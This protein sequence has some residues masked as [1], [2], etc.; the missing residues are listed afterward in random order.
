MNVAVATWW[1]SSTLEVVHRC[2]QVPVAACLT[3][4]KK[5][6]KSW[7]PSLGPGDEMILVEMGSRPRPLDAFSSDQGKLDAALESLRPLDVEPDLRAAL[8][9]ARDI[10]SAR[11]SPEIIVVGD[12]R[13]GHGASAEEIENLPPLRF[14]N[15]T[16]RCNPNRKTVS[17][18]LRVDLFSARRY[19]LSGDRFEVLLSVS[20][21]GSEPVEV[22]LSISAMG[23]EGQ[24]G[25]LLEVVRREILPGAPNAFSFANLSQ[26]EDGL[27]AEIRRLDG[28]SDSLLSD[29]WALAV[30]PRRL[31]VRVLIVGEPDNFLEAALLIEDSLI[32]KSVL[33]QDYER[34]GEF[35]VTV[36]NGVAPKRV[37]R[38]GAAV[39]LGPSEE[40]ETQGNAE[41]FPVERGPAISMFGFDTWDKDSRVFQLV[42]PYDVQVLSGYALVPKSEDRVLAKSEDRPILIEGRRD[43]GS[44]LALG[45][46]PIKSDFVLR[47]AW[48]LF[49]IN[50]IDELYPRGRGDVIS[51]GVASR[52]LRVP[53]AR[54]EANVA[55]VEGPL[56]DGRTPLSRLVP[57][58]D[59]YA[60]IYAQQAGFYDVATESGTTRIAVSPQHAPPSRPDSIEP[61]GG[62]R[63]AG[64]K[65]TQPRDMEPRTNYDPWFWL[66]AGVLGI[67][68]L[69]WWSY[70]RRLTV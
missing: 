27:L 30:L 46:R 58:I 61:S 47:P 17:S 2:L 41:H 6:I 11:T 15:M 55:R 22:E 12:D 68:Y 24:R 66:I 50:L 8:L 52:E 14:E 67:S 16:S 29:N 23:P 35:D 36:F 54:G 64:Q 60:V 59:G 62:D 37:P 70:H 53:V 20:T 49:V 43:S 18:N 4:A 45:F 32:V 1:Y 13:L 19:P 28:Q 63:L 56:L 31:P 7:F 42:D 69:E 51:T 26:A 39:Y 57:V 48:P 10:L 21:N 25:D 33:P 5:L 38:T 40:G 9:F 44:F 65:V 34:A 3:E